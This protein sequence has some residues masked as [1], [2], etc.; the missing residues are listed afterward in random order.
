MNQGVAR[1]TGVHLREITEFARYFFTSTLPLLS[2]GQQEVRRTVRLCQYASNRGGL[3][4]SI[5]KLSA[6]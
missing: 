1:N 6:G 2:T 3:R 4:R 5:L